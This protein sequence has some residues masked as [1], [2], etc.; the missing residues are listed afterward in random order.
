MLRCCSYLFGN[1]LTTLPG[2]LL[3]GTSVEKLWVHERWSHQ[4]WAAPVKMKREAFFI[5][6]QMCKHFLL[7]IF[8]KFVKEVSCIVWLLWCLYIVVYLW[9][10]VN[11]WFTK[12]QE[13]CPLHYLLNT[14][15]RSSFFVWWF[16]FY[17][18]F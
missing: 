18:H 14:R 1:R 9:T 8:E 7:F 11:I 5:K 16:F 10:N 4:G 6:L 12:W 15:Y 3:V 17:I 13:A 2:S